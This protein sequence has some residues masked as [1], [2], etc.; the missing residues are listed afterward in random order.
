MLFSALFVLHT[1]ASFAAAKPPLYR[2]PPPEHVCVQASTIDASTGSCDDNKLFLKQAQ[3]CWEKVKSIHAQV[4]KDFQAKVGVNPTGGQ[5]QDFGT[6]KADQ[7]EAVAAHGY[8]LKVAETALDDLDKYFDTVVLPDDLGH[9]SDAEVL[10]EPCYHD[11]VYPMD[12]I[13]E[14]LE[15]KID[16]MKESKGLEGL[17]GKTSGARQ[18][19]TGSLNGPQ[20]NGGKAQAGAP[21]AKKGDS[22]NGASDI[23]GTEENKKKQAQ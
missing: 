20:V 15:D 19:N 14:Q 11:A 9:M 23:T 6:S 17:M 21:K 4:T 22:K 13:A 12:Q 8:M 3:D 2:Q 5:N 16:E 10:A 18:G 7:D 1:T